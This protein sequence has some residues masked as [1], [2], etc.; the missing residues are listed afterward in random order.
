MGLEATR[1]GSVI[2]YKFHFGI[3]SFPEGIGTSSPT[4]SSPDGVIDIVGDFTGGSN[5]TETIY[6]WFPETSPNCT[7][8]D[9]LSNSSNP[10][11]QGLGN[12]A[13]VGCYNSTLESITISDTITGNC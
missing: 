10:N 1:S 11:T 3:D 5:F 4:L 6:Y 7:T 2:G 8:D 12:R 13:G 9:A